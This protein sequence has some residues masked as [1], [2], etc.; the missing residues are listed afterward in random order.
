ME[1]MEQ[2]SCRAM[3]NDM[4]FPAD[5]GEGAEYSAVYRTCFE[6]P[7]KMQCRVAGIGEKHGIWGG[8]SPTER[9][10]YRNYVTPLLPNLAA[11]DWDDRI[12]EWTDAVLYR[13][14]HGTDLVQALLDAGL[15]K[16]GV[17]AVFANTNG[18]RFAMRT[19]AKQEEVTTMGK[20]R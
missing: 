9:R 3:N 18:D 6:C 7:V 8:S 14:D 10:A 4:F 2:A 20:K 17:Q 13:S 5:N 19:L 15:S 11:Y 12:R 16:F 1:W